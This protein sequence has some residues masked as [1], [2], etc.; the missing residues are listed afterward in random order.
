MGEM[1]QSWPDNPSQNDKPSRLAMSKLQLQG[2]LQ[3]RRNKMRK[4]SLFRTF[5]IKLTSSDCHIKCSPFHYT[6]RVVFIIG[7]LNCD[8]N[9]IWGLP[10]LKTNNNRKSFVCYLCEL[11]KWWDRGRKN[12]QWCNEIKMSEYATY[13]MT[14]LKCL[15]TRKKH[16]SLLQQCGQEFY[17]NFATDQNS[18]CMTI[19]NWR[20]KLLKIC[21]SVRF[22]L[23]DFISAWHN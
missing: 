21:L 6:L 3:Q 4:N 18:I 12:V 22:S 2:E 15:S 11:S 16:N 19:N 14:I 7:N 8:L 10:H 1:Y 20:Q 5:W 17:L 23:E 13:L 9:K